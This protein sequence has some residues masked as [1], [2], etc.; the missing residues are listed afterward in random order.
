MAIYT[1]I[2]DANGDFTVPFSSSYTSGQKV[3]VIAEKDNATKTIE[4]HAP[5]SITGGGVIQFN[6]SLD[7]FPLNIGDITITGLTG[8]IGANA[9]RS[10]GSYGNDIDIYSRATGL[11]INHGVTSLG[12]FAF[13]SWK[14][15]KSLALPTSLKTIGE[16]AFSGW[17]ALT[18]LNIPEGVTHIGSYAFM[19]LSYCT[20]ITLPSTILSISDYALYA[21]SRLNSVTCMAV[22]PPTLAGT[23]NFTGSSYNVIIKVPAGS[24]DAY[25]AAPGWSVHAARI[26]AI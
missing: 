20:S 10:S 8:A 17:S 7:N 9:F 19:A 14:A 13:S 4:L 24:V 6:G 22:I 21:L 3:T 11:T 1:G 15:A 2:A 12:N 5:S 26:Q 16:Y 23:A 25:K 18:E